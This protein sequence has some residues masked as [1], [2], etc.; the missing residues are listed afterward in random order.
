[1]RRTTCTVVLL[2]AL[3]SVPSHGVVLEGVC[4]E[5]IKVLSSHLF[6]NYLENRHE[7]KLRGA[8]SWYYKPLD[9]QHVCVYATAK[10]DIEAVDKSREKTRSAM[11]DEINKIMTLVAEEQEKRVIVDAK[12]KQIVEAFKF[13]SEVSSFVD[14]HLEIDRMDYRDKIERAFA[15][16]CISKQEIVSYEEKRMHEL[17][18]SIINKR[19]SSAFDE[20]DSF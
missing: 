20:L 5:L 9:D 18:L 8:P 13:D 2:C 17:Q 19:S 1:M 15:R 14:R 6:K 11:M 10:G 16:G 12:D 3:T 7:V 4:L